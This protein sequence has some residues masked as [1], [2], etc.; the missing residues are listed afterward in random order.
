MRLRR[1]Y[2][3]ILLTTLFCALSA[4]DKNTA[5]PR[6]KLIITTPQNATNY[7][8]N[9]NQYVLL[10]A[11][12]HLATKD[13][14]TH[15]FAPWQNKTNFQ[16]F[17]LHKTTI[18]IKNTEF[19]NIDYYAHHQSWNEDY[20]PHPTRWTQS[21]VSNMDM[22][23]YPNLNKNAITITNTAVR[24]LPTEQPAFNN[25][26]LAG[27]GYPFDN[28]QLEALWAGTPIHIM[29]QT[30]DHAWVLVYAPGTFGWV[31]ISDI[32]Y[33]DKKFISEWQNNHYIVITK[34]NIAINDQQG[35][36]R[37]KSRIG[38]IYPSKEKSTIMIP[39]ADMNKKAL[40]KTALISP[41]ISTQFPMRATQGNMA[42]II[43]QF[44]GQPYGWGGLN[45]YRDC[46]STMH[47]L[48]SVFGLWLPFG[49]SHQ[50]KHGEAVSLAELSS[51]NRMKLIAKNAIPF[52]TLLAYK[53]HVTLYLGQD[54]GV[55]VV[56][57]DSWGLKTHSLLGR[58]GRAIIAGTVINRVDVKADGWAHTIRFIDKPITMTFIMPSVN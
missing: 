39:I 5:A 50:L 6:S 21:I 37:F 52:A 47:D 17:P 29:Q 3:L 31:K 41:Q 13:Y 45:N 32:A 34:D 58:E 49:S 28:L 1:F 19:A 56:F 33:V 35:F 2:Q 40:T 44:L 38:A 23:T 10:P 55:P 42:T 11:Y 22:T 54:H 24:A 43:N 20:Q 26:A 46:S 48:F 57:Q 12:Q 14:L 53:G 25:P 4:C 51:N 7:A 36:F 18:N 30:K 27:E 9:P 16:Y 15:F 8:T